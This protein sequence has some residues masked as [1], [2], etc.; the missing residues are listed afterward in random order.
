MTPTMFRDR[1]DTRSDERS[2]QVILQVALPIPD[3]VTEGLHEPWLR[4]AARKK[5]LLQHR[6]HLVRVVS[7]IP[8]VV[9]V[10]PD[11]G[12]REIL[13]QGSESAVARMLD[14]LEGRVPGGIQIMEDARSV[15]AAHE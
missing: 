3:S 14:D 1:L 13:V 2:L 15:V 4:S 7:E 12:S 5:F 8:H 11:V 6:D 10:D 9:V